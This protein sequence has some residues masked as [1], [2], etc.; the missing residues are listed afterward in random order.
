MRRLLVALL[1][2]AFAVPAFAGLN[3]G[4]RAFISFRPNCPTPTYPTDPYVHSVVW[5]GEKTYNSFL[6]VDCF[7]NTLPPPDPALLGMRSIAMRWVTTASDPA[8]PPDLMAALYYPVGAQ[9]IGAPDQDKWVIAWPGCEPPNACGFIKVLRQGYYAYNP[10][11]IDLLPNAVDGKKVVDCNFESDQFC[12][13][14]NGA[15]GET[16]HPGD[17]GCTCPIPSAVEGASWGGIK[18]LYR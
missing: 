7:G 17:L 18:A 5:T 12:V 9:V 2:L 8:Y 13:L 14:S 1:I 10:F 4:V 15:V 11:W 16:P 3:P 6:C